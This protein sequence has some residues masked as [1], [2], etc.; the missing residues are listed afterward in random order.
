MRWLVASWKWRHS[1]V[2]NFIVGSVLQWHVASPLWWRMHIPLVRCDRDMRSTHWWGTSAAQALFR[3]T[4]QLSVVVGMDG[5]IYL[6]SLAWTVSTS[7]YCSERIY[8]FLSVLSSVHVTIT[9]WMLIY[10]FSLT[11][12]S[13]Q[14]TYIRRHQHNSLYSINNLKQWPGEALRFRH[15]RHRG[16]RDRTEHKRKRQWLPCTVTWHS[17]PW[18]ENTWLSLV[19]KK[20]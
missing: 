9:V 11:A 15:Q 8:I 7:K 6:K 5:G 12:S 1:P 16:R 10:H 3:G 20:E 18:D 4:S 17:F 13:Y 14:R 19:W 2:K